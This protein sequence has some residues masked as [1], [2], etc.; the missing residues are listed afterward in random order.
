MSKFYKRNL[1][2]TVLVFFALTIFFSRSVYGMEDKFFEA[3]K[4]TILA[5]P[6]IQVT[7]ANLEDPQEKGLQVVKGSIKN[8]ANTCHKNFF[9][10]V[11]EFLIKENFP[12]SG[13]DFCHKNLSSK[14]LE[15]KIQ[16][17]LAY[18]L[19]M[20]AL[21]APNYKSN[22]SPTPKSVTTIHQLK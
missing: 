18:M 1:S 16:Y 8:L 17:R 3:K 9:S 12:T 7:Q 20:E 11:L 2:V 5:L 14:E 13:F 10:N 22:R 15:G 19:L 4:T 21:I 6:L